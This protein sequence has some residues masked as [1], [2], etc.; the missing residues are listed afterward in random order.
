MSFARSV[1]TVDYIHSRQQ[2][3][4]SAQAQQRRLAMIVT[5]VLYV[6][7]TKYDMNTS[8]HNSTFIYDRERFYKIEL[9]SFIEEARPKTKRSPYIFQGSPM[10]SS[11]VTSS[12]AYTRAVL[13]ELLLT[14]SHR[15]VGRFGELGGAS[16][17]QHVVVIGEYAEDA[18]GQFTLANLRQRHSVGPAASPEAPSEP[19]RIT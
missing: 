12:R 9:Q 4:G 13:V 7:G 16:L 11:L 18:G 3:C 17:E 19:A 6:P 2:D 15:H 10:R 5:F 14:I 8:F 1:P